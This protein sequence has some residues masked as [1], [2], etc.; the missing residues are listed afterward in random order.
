MPDNLK[1]PTSHRRPRVASFF[2]GAGGLDIGFSEAGFDIVMATDFDADCCETLRLNEGRSISAGGKVLRA[3]IREI[4]SAELPENIDVVIGGPPCQSFS[5]SGRRAGGAAG[6]LDARGTLFRAYRDCIAHMQPK[7]FLFENVRGIFATNKGQDWREI[8]ASFQEIGYTLSHRVLDAADYGA[9]QHRERVFLV[10]LRD[11]KEFQFP[12]PTHGPDSSS[13]SKHVSPLDAFATIKNT[14]QDLAKTAFT[15]GKYSHLLAEVPEGDNYLYFTQKRGY[16]SPI[17]AYRSRFSDFLYKASPYHPMK[18]IIASPGKYTGPLH[19]DNRYF[20]LPEYKAIQGFPHDYQFY[21][22]R[23]SI[24][25]QIGNSVS[26]HVALHLAKSIMMQIFGGEAVE[27]L[28]ASQKLGFDRRKGVKAAKT[29]A[30]HQK[31]EATPSTNDLF[32]LG[33]YQSFVGP[34][35][36][37][38]TKP[39]CVAKVNGKQISIEVYHDGSQ[40][41]FCQ[42]TV[43][44]WQKARSFSQEP[45]ALVTVKAFGQADETIQTAWNAIDQWIIHSSAYHSLFEAYGHFTEP[46]PIF[47]VV[48]FVAHSRRPILSFAQ[49]ITDFSYCSRYMDRNELQELLGRSFGTMDEGTTIERLRRMRFDIRTRETNI[50]IPAGKYMIAYPFTLPSRKQMNIKMRLTGNDSAQSYITEQR[51]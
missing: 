5:A 39:N 40:E 38:A 10:G 25:K 11:G 3:D 41:K 7:A 31:I 4:T 26:P 47:K 51:R 2:A 37:T 34:S 17:F 50:A 18:T 27:T 36:L 46:Y 6:S 33:P 14:K 9:P 30:M 35:V 22:E 48:E 20:S 49:L 32:T 23:A 12:A 43:A 1:Q 8:V 29:R 42:F 45:V 13:G 44:F 19:W 24:V 16:P 21:G 15:G 28:Q